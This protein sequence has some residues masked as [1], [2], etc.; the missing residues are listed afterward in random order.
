MTT[1]TIKSNGSRWAGQEPATVDELLDVLATHPL[2]S[3]FEKYGNF[4]TDCDG[5]LNYL[6][7]PINYPA[8]SVKFWGN[9]RD[10][11]HVFDIVTNDATTIAALT[12][13]IRSNQKRAD[14]GPR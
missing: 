1:T 4:I 3:T 9:F 12:T 5:L 7:K 14:Y 8:G 10:L 6:G 13:A 2:D 11:S